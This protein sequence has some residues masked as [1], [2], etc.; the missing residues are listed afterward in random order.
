MMS[1]PQRTDLMHTR[2]RR[3][4]SRSSVPGSLPVL[5]FGDLFQA[6]AV[7]VGL[8]PSDREYVDRSGNE[9]EGALRRFETMASL[10]AAARDAL[11]AD[12]CERAIATMRDYYGPGK[13]VYA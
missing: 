5:F 2:L 1:D 12:Q 7:T 8:N 4:P 3:A 11:T 9:L 6:R 13:P 10:G